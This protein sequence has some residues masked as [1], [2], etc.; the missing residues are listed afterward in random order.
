MQRDASGSSASGDEPPFSRVADRVYLWSMVEA[1]EAILL[2]HFLTHYLSLGIRSSHAHI[3]LQG[4][5]EILSPALHVLDAFSVANRSVA[6]VYSSKIKAGLVNG[7]LRT[8]PIDA[9]L[10]YPDADEMFHFDAA[11][12]PSTFRSNT[13]TRCCPTCT[14]TTARASSSPGAI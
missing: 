2:R 1:T 9:W 12:P 6:P 8:L 10:V 7:F 3:C 13:K 11:L 5:N 4:E 14:N